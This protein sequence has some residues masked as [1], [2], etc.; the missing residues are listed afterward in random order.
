[1]PPAC[2]SVNPS[3]GQ[4]RPVNPSAPQLLL[5]TISPRPTHVLWD[6]WV[7]TEGKEGRERWWRLWERSTWHGDESKGDRLWQKTSQRFYQ[8]SL[9]R[10]SC[11][12]AALLQLYIFPELKSGLAVL[13]GSGHYDCYCLTRNPELTAGLQ[14]D[15]KTDKHSAKLTSFSLLQTSPCFSCWSA[16][17]PGLSKCI[18]CIYKLCSALLH[19]HITLIC[20]VWG[21]G[22]EVPSVSVASAALWITVTVHLNSK[23]ENMTPSNHWKPIVSAL[24][25]LDCVWH[26][27]FE[28]LYKLYWSVTFILLVDH[29]KADHANWEQIWVQLFPY[30]YFHFPSSRGRDLEELIHFQPVKVHSHFLK[31][32]KNNNY[33]WLVAGWLVSRK[34]EHLSV[35]LSGRTSVFLSEARGNQSIVSSW[36]WQ[37][38]TFS[39]SY[40]LSSVCL[41]PLTPLPFSLW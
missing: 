14:G 29:L 41:F 24:K 9:D 8:L 16:L 28:Q 22:A 17:R 13:S 34:T 20:Y 38:W 15:I 1:M 23:S 21:R 7:G 37:V 26:F 12:S 33:Y 32:K 5:K 31:E 4:H 3:A 25:L 18:V 30:L 19:P 39:T 40:N 6:L 27:Y 36:N 11:L 10:V 2:Q 35:A